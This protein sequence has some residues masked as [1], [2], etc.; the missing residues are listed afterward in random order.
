AAIDKVGE[1]QYAVRDP[2]M[3]AQIL[4]MRDDPKISALMAGA[5][6]NH[7][8]EGVSN[9]LGRQPT[10]GELFIAHFFGLAGATKLINMKQSQP[11]ASAASAFPAP[12]KANRS[13]FYDRSGHAKSAAAVYA[14][15][16]AKHD[17]APNLPQTQVA[18]AG[19]TLPIRE[20]S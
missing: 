14:T 3:R 11:N 6:P 9:L 13:I 17:F 8:A 2:A 4:K 20:A 10:S 15:L 1:G 18:S 12:A 16:V 5:L 19:S 7:K